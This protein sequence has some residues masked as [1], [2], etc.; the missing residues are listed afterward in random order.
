MTERVS[1]GASEDRAIHVS[2]PGKL[3]L[4]GEYV[5]LEGAPALVAAIQLRASATWGSATEHAALPL[6]VA[7]TQRIIRAELGDVSGE[8]AVDVLRLRHSEHKLG[9]GSSAAAAV[10]AAGA[11]AEAHGIGV[12]VGVGAT[13]DRIF[14]WAFRGHSEIAPHGSGIDVAAS[15]YGGVLRF[16][17]SGT[18]PNHR[19]LAWPGT[20]HASVIFTGSSA[21]TS[22]LVARVRAHTERHP[23]EHATIMATLRSLSTEFIGA[24]E[25]GEPVG[26]VEAAGHYHDALAELGRRAHAPIIEERLGELASLARSCGGASKPSGAGGGDVAVAFFA[27][28]SRRRAFDDACRLR[29]FLVVDAPLG[30]DGVRL[31]ASP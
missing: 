25:R 30:G 31:E 27:D 12:S 3:V 16:E 20:L 10:A 23:R 29:G 9:V 2:A 15:T 1:H 24:F 7:A 8:L 5:V 28:S 21:R 17:R 13:R 19:P 4:V 14:D 26:V 22:G 11:L 6:E 18:R